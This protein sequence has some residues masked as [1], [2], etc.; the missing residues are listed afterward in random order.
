MNLHSKEPSMPV[1]LIYTV[2]ILIFG[3]D[4]PFHVSVMDA[5]HNT[6]SRTIQVSHRLFLDD[7]EDG[8]KDFHGLD[9]VDTIEPEDE[10]YLDSLISK[11]L[12]SKVFFVIDGEEKAFKY[13]G[14]E[15]EGDAR[16]C[17]YEVEE[18]SDLKQ[19]EITNVALMD[20][21]DDQQNIIHLKAK[22]KIQSYKLDKRTKVKTFSFND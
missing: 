6:E 15:L 22:G 5:E 11:Y 2:L 14:S 12:E 18:V 3:L 1:K 4:H 10:K 17:Y 20:V 21:F 13:F 7:L 8:L 19:V 16:W 9:Y